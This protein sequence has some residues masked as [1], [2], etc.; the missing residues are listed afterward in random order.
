MNGREDRRRQKIG[1]DAPA[2]CQQTET[3][4]E[5]RVCGGCTKRD[6]QRRV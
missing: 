2:V 4:A 6:D 1:D 5:E 3:A